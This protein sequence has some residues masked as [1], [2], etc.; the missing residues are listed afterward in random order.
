MSGIQL[1]I[2]VYDIE[3]ATIA[4]KNGAH[5]VELCAAPASGGTT[6]GPGT[7]VTARNLL[8]IQLFVMIRPRGGDFLYTE[9]EFKTMLKDIEFVKNA[10]ADGV[11]TGILKADGSID[12]HRTSMLVDL[13]FPMQVTFHR[14]FDMT[15]NSARA[16][17]DVIA[18]GAQ[19]ILTSGKQETAVQGEKTIAALVKQAGNRISIMA[20]SGITSENVVELI[21]LTGVKEIHLSAKKTYPSAMH[22]AN[23]NLSMGIAKNQEYQIIRADGEEIRRVKEK[24]SRLSQ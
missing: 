5:R 23:P 24:I 13:A 1:E 6:P 22:Y 10:G 2:C 11:V 12:I 9:Q 3:S 7:I 18:T 8:S 17:E 15:D 21:H 14:A 19:R 4:Q 20:G 16:L